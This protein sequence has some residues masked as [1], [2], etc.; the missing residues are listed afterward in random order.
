MDNASQ[1]IPHTPE[2][3]EPRDN[4]QPDLSSAVR[5]MEI[6]IQ[7]VNRPNLPPL[8]QVKGGRA[9]VW[10]RVGEIIAW[11]AFSTL[12]VNVTTFL[13]TSVLEHVETGCYRAAPIGW[14]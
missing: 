10:S 3:K 13:V 12:A 9:W 5:V 6:L 7:A 1:W 8:S 14:A 4:P 2:Q 11:S